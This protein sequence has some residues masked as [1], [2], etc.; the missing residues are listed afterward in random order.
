MDDHLDNVMAKGTFKLKAHWNLRNEWNSYH[1][2]L[3]NR[4]GG[5]PRMAIFPNLYV[6]LK[7]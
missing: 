4:L 1:Y 3:I 2:D 6:R 7:L 5:C